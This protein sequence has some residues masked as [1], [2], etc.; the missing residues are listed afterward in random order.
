MLPLNPYDLGLVT[1]KQE[2]AVGTNL[3]A[4]PKLDMPLDRA[5][6]LEA[7]YANVDIKPG[8]T[9][10]DIINAIEMSTF[11]L[12]PDMSMPS[13]SPRL[14]R[15]KERVATYESENDVFGDGQ[16]NYDRYV[17]DRY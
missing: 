7:A 3:D 16:A 8:M 12:T 5:I 14:P 10:G 2:P 17:G 6:E 9:Y 1:Y 4:V 15:I 13:E 11:Q